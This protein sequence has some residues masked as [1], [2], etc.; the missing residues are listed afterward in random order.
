M[1]V[2][3]LQADLSLAVNLYRAVKLSMSVKLFM[4]VNLSLTVK[5][6]ALNSLCISPKLVVHYAII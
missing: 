5:F 3:F 1:T 2:P 6:T 4:E